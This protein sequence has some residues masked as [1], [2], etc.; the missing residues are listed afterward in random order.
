[1]KIT[2]ILATSIAALTL[3]SMAQAAT[4]VH[5]TGSTAYRASTIQ[6]IEALMITGTGGG[7]YVGAGTVAAPTGPAITAGKYKCSYAGAS[8][9][10]GEQAATYVILEGNIPG[11]NNPVIVK[12]AWA[13]STGGLIT[14]VHNIDVDWTATSGFL[15]ANTLTGA[16]CST[17]GDANCLSGAATFNSGDGDT[18]KKAHITMADSQQGSAGITGLIAGGTNGDGICAVIPFEWVASNGVTAP[19]KFTGCTGTSGNPVINYTGAIYLPTGAAATAPQIAAVVGGP[20]GGPSIARNDFVTAAGGGSFTLT[21][22]PTATPG[23]TYV[24]AVSGVCPATNI[25]VNQSNQLVS[26]GLLL[27]QLTGNSAHTTPVYVGGRN[28]DSGTRLSQLA[29]TGIGIFGVQQSVCPTFVGGQAYPIAFPNAGTRG[30]ASSPANGAGGADQ[31]VSKMD[32]WAAESIFPAPYTN[33]YVLGNSGYNGGGGLAGF[34]ATAGSST[35]PASTIPS[36]PFFD[37]NNSGT[38][39]GGWVIGYLGRSDAKTACKSNVG[40][41]TAHRINF[42]GYADWTGG[43]GD[44]AMA[45][46][47]GVTYD[48]TTIQEG[49]Y[50]AW[51]VEYLY[52]YSGVTADQQTVADKLTDKL[53]ATPTSAAGVKYGDMHVGKANEGAP[54]YHN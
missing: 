27:S 13:G 8:A 30:S 40:A 49:L 15:S 12:T 44:A 45:A 36:A 16:E 54:I 46:D 52:T 21:T 18:G 20:C 1:M 37:S 3:G 26:T 10:A 33:N 47:G 35:A 51:E 34:L 25:T 19:V 28:F 41:N 48:N 43:T 31:Y 53:L 14:T 6:G 22:A 50:Q 23:T 7:N 5:I 24:A 32:L 11:C 2:S 4:V 42:S 39:T 9:T 29:E 38:A 17:T